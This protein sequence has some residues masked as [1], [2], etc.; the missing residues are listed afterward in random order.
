MKLLLITFNAIDDHS[1]GAAIRSSHIRDSMTEIGDLHTVVIHGS[2]HFQL[3][4]QWSQDGVKYGLYNRFGV[5]YAAWRQRARIREWLSKL[6]SEY[7]YDA[8]VARYLGLALFVPRWA[9]PRL[10]VDADDIVKSLPTKERAS[11]ARRAQRWVRNFV[12]LC[13]VRRAGYVWCVNPVDALRIGTKRVSVL[14]N[15]VY[16]PNP[17]RPKVRAIPGR[18]LMVG[19]FEHPPNA[20]GLRWFVREIV[21]ALRCGR[22]PIELHAVGKCPSA[23]ATELGPSIVVRGFVPDLQTE[24][25]LASLVVAPI[26]S[27]GGTQIK[28]I[29]ALAHARPLVASAFAHAGFAKELQPVEHLLVCSNKAEWILACNSVLGNADAAEA[30]A[31]RGCVGAASFGRDSLRETM[32]AT[33]NIIARRAALPRSI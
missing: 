1:Y 2:N 29:D 10:V 7:R 5:S 8:I 24:Y 33:F 20:D 19:L 27:G 6:I 16:T 12:A 4:Q 30:M 18:I 9:W 11:A 32:V 21:P 22:G 3:D 25:D 14:H 31:A 23:L 28:V 26:E 17:N 13:A 15:V